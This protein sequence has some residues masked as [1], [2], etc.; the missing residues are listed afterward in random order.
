MPDD[1]T[2]AIFEGRAVGALD[3]NTL[4]V[5]GAP[6]MEV[7]VAEGRDSMSLGFI[8]GEIVVDG[9]G[10]YRAVATAPDGSSYEQTL[11]PTDGKAAVVGAT[12]VEDPAGTWTLEFEALGTG[13]ALVEAVAY[14][15]L[16]FELGSPG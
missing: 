16:R 3:I 15:S 9:Q 11:L 13:G 10:A 8:L 12:H 4:P 7:D 6:V 5:P 14:N 2:L 1:P